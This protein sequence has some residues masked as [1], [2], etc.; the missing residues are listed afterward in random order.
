MKGQG[1]IGTMLITG[2]TILT[3]MIGAWAT[4]ADKVADVRVDVAAVKANADSYKEETN[5]RLEAIEGKM[6]EQVKLSNE[7]LLRISKIR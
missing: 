2:G 6:D 3:A 1:L 7:I 4:A 5:R